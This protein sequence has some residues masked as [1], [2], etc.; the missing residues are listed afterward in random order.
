MSTW[1]A[2]VVLLA[3]LL[4]GTACTSKGEGPTEITLQR[5]FGACDAQYGAS[6]DVAAA[7]EAQQANLSSDGKSAAAAPTTPMAPSL[8]FPATGLARLRPAIWIS[9]C[10]GRSA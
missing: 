9:P 10:P 7:E 5:F 6:T 4:T 2:S 3:V 1:F 8:G